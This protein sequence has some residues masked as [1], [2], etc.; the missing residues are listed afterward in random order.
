MDQYPVLRVEDLFTILAGGP[1]F[2]KLDLLHAYQQVLIKPASR[3]YVTVNMH[4]EL[5]QDNWLP[6]GVAYTPAVFQ[7]TMEKFPQWSSTFSSRAKVMRKNA[8]P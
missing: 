2:S 1:K 8:S 5:Y 6:F 7:Q 4:K 3:K